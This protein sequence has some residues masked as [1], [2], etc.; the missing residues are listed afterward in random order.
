MNGKIKITNLTT[1]NVRA[2]DECLTDEEKADVS[3]TA[4]TATFDMSAEEAVAL[5]AAVQGRIAVKRGH[6]YQSLAAVARKL[7][8]PATPPRPARGSSNGPAALRA[9]LRL[10]G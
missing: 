4:T 1:L 3:T 7:N 8:A 6:P 10:D 2:L 5:I 9:V